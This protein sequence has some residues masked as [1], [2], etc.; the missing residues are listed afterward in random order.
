MRKARVAIPSN[1]K[2]KSGGA[3]TIYFHWASEALLLFLFVYPKSKQEDLTPADKKAHC[4]V[5]DQFKE[6][7]DGSKKI[8]ARKSS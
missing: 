2:G 6:S 4:A 3:R 8:K 5:L 7:Y 1:G